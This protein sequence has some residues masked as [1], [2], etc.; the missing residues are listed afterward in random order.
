MKG[1]QAIIAGYICLDITPD[2]SAIPKGDFKRLF[3]PGRLIQAN[4]MFCNP[5]GVVSNTGLSLYR[6]GIPVHII[7]KIGNDLYGKVLQDIIAAE[8]MHLGH[9]L[10]VDLTL[11]TGFTI[12]INPP[13]FDRT[14]ISHAGANNTFYAS[15]L[16]RSILQEGDLFH[17]GYPPLMRS[18]YRSGGAE[19]ISILI[20]ARRAGLTTS[21]DFSLPDLTS[22]AGQIDWSTFLE[23]TLPFVDLFVPSFEELLFL[24]ERPTFERLSLN[25]TIPFV[26]AAEPGLLNNLAKK[27]LN[28]GVKALLVKIGHR[29]VY[30]K[31]A[32][33]ERWGKGGRALDSLDSLWYDREMWAPAF[34]SQAISTT[35]A[36]DAA[37]AGF[38]A[39]VL[40]ETSPET[41]LQIANAAGAISTETQ[42]V[43]KNLTA[44][45]EVWSRIQGGW[46]I[47]P[48]NLGEFGWHKDQSNGLWFS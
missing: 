23:N 17:F 1:K 11:P 37:I 26:E 27:V 19:L 28:Y 40:Q 20:R 16:P 4:G 38:L 48:L 5:G 45:N 13:G 12:I 14:F 42:L 34:Q 31:T 46:D 6:L 10:V 33:A 21:L 22:P 3:K 8:S 15:D 24:F 25:S 9:D 36:G 7:G 44:W 29:G 35:G 32:P 30:L 47:V 2:L 18:I 41:A 39:S 43:Y